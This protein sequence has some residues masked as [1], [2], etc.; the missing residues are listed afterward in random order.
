MS[1]SSAG[2]PGSSPEGS[3]SHSGPLTIGAVV[4]SLGA[5]VVS[6]AAVSRSAASSAEPEQLAAT[7]AAAKPATAPRLGIAAV[8]QRSAS[9]FAGVTTL[10]L[11][12]F[13]LVTRSWGPAWDPTRGRREQDGW[14]EHAAFMDGLL[15]EGFVIMGG[16]VGE[17]VD[18]G[19]AMVVVEAESEDEV[20]DRLSG[21]P[22]LPDLLTV[23]PVEPWTLWLRSHRVRLD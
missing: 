16:P 4:V 13:F 2:A 12:P 1:L 6:R 20:R 21:D 17:D 22:W 5:V 23:G 11:M 10:P 18:G 8:S 7:I 15:D 19:H 14:E 3:R 9:G